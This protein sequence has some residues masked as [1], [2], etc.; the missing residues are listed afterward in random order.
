MHIWKHYKILIVP[1]DNIRYSQQCSDSDCHQSVAKEIRSFLEKK[2]GHVKKTV[3]NFYSGFILSNFDVCFFL[4]M[5]VEV[6]NLIWD[7][8]SFGFIFI[9]RYIYIYGEC[10][11][12]VCTFP[13]SRTFQLQK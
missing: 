4:R 3:I 5:G 13:L 2:N 12:S 11:Y 7:G 1:Q 9:P 6:C 10:Q 8:A